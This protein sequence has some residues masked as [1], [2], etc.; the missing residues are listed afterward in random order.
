MDLKELLGAIRRGWKA[1]AVAFAI[2]VAIALVAIV[3]A[4]P[5]YSSQTRLFVSL[6]GTGSA[7]ELQ[8]GSTFTEA[9]AVTYAETASTPVVLGPVIEDL[10]LEMT[11][12]ELS[13]HITASAD[14]ETVLITITASAAQ[15]DTAADIAEATAESLISIVEE[16][17]TPNSDDES[18]VNLSVVAPAT[19]PTSASSPSIP[20]YL[21]TGVILGLV[22]GAAAAILRARFDTRIRDEAGIRRV[23]QL[24]LLGI[25]AYD[26]DVA[27]RPLITQVRQLS[28]R[29]EAF[30]HLRTNLQFTQFDNE[31]NSILV[32]SSLPG[33]GKTSTAVNLAISFAEAN[34]RVAI[35]EADLRRPRVS[36]YLGLDGS[37][38]LTTVLLGKVDLDSAL[39]PWRSDRLRVLASGKLPPNP[40]ELLGSSAMRKL[41]EDLHKICD[42]VIIDGP[43][44]LPVTD[45][46]IISQTVGGVLLVVSAKDTNSV[47]VQKSMQ[48]L[49]L[50]GARFLGTVLNKSQVKGTDAYSYRY[51]ETEGSVADHLTDEWAVP[52]EPVN[53]QQQTETH[54]PAQLDSRPRSATMNS[55]TSP[56]TDRTRSEERGVDTEST[57]APLSLDEVDSIDFSGRGDRE[58]RSNNGLLRDEAPM[59]LQ[60]ASDDQH[61]IQS[62]GHDLR[63]T[64]TP[65]M[66][67]ST[68]KI[69]LSSN[70]EISSTVV[71]SGATYNEPSA[72]PIAFDDVVLDDR[73]TNDTAISRRG[74]HAR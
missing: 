8:Q 63:S 7:L 51:Y 13:K 32:T 30:R 68:Q 10:N 67:T 71:N 48:S 19:V 21:A 53:A 42:I 27:K 52:N 1:F 69:T 11:P 62:V 6:Q 29:S 60:R 33:E 31:H 25:I 36:K 46:A 16:L 22:L 74:R 24:P 39:Q 65:T 64:Q 5:M 37:V 66:A 9:R 26:S 56:S 15:P 4:R 20:G 57:R 72:T 55:P 35:I 18:P 54:P 44:V 3:V 70:D 38:G 28:P 14:P 34:Q 59:H 2:C 50:V 17:E 23:T 43:P 12:D 47:A 61:R 41:L 49:E 58:T 45:S 40:S 73:S